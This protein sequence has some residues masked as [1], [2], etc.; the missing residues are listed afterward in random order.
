MTSENLSNRHTH[1][2]DGGYMEVGDSQ[3]V[4]PWLSIITPVKDALSEL[5]STCQSLAIQD[6][7]SVEWL[8]V[9]SSS[10]NE[11]VPLF[12]RQRAGIPV[13]YIRQEP[14]GI[15]AAMNRGVTESAGHY[16]Y[17]LNAGDTLLS[18]ESLAALRNALAANNS[19]PWAHA[20]VEMVDDQGGILAP[21]P[22][23]HAEERSRFFARGYFPCHQGTVVRGSVIR[24]LGGFDTSYVIGGDY[25]L[26]LRIDRLYPP[27][28]LPFTLA[29]FSPGGASSEHWLTAL[30][31]FHRARR[32][33]LRP[34][35]WA[36]ARERMD[37]AWFGGKTALYR[38]LWAP[39]RPLHRAVRRIGR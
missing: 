11:E 21:A 34:S 16:V 17:F 6:F 12:I 22:W 19:P 31:E 20:D 26:F 24:S 23:D 13:T 25:E 28:H 9:D 5:Q 2:V 36:A 37:T 30:R 33:S 35:G 27:T 10:D 3:P 14:R 32:L 39:G 1:R 8:I 4:A 7:S 38:S 18:S 15:F 29:R